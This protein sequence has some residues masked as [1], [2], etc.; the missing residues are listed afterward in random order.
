MVQVNQ[1]KFDTADIL[2]R[3]SKLNVNK[4]ASVDGLHPRVLYELRLV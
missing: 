2:L 4:S 3:L 1:L